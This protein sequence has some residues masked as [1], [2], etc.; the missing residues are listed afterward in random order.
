MNWKAKAQIILGIIIWAVPFLAYGA[1][2]YYSI[3]LPSSSCHSLTCMASGIGS[4][5]SSDS[6]S[7]A[8]S[9]PASSSG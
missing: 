1:T 6:P 9:H 3:T 7:L 2:W 4:A 8:L 5:C